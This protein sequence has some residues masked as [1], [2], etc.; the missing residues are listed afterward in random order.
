MFKEYSSSVKMSTIYKI[1]EAVE[2]CVMSVK[3]FM[4]GVRLRIHVLN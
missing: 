4:L 1:V 3:K 2:S